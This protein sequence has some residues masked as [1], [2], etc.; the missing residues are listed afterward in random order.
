[1]QA[2]EGQAGEENSLQVVLELYEATHR[3]RIFSPQLTKPWRVVLGPGIPKLSIKLYKGKILG[4][5]GP[6]GAGKTTL[7]R[8]M[9]GIYPIK[10]GEARVCTTNDGITI[11]E[12]GI[13]LRQVVG[14]MPEQVRW[15][16][17]KT[18]RMALLEIAG[19][20]GA[21]E[22]RVDGLLKLVGLRGRA[23]TNLNSLSQGMRQR[24]TLA[25]ALLGSPDVL[26]LDEPFNGLDPVAATALADLLKRL[27]EK[28]VSI[29]I[30]SHRVE[31][32]TELVDRI[33]VLHRGQLLAE[34]EIPDIEREL[35]LDY[36]HN[37]ITKSPV[38][39]EFFEDLGIEVLQ[40]KKSINYEY[41]LKNCPQNTLESLIKF[42]AEVIT[43]Q[44]HEV[45]LVEIIC[46][47][48]GQSIEEVGLEVSSSAILPMR[49]LEV[50]EE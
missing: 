30:S 45:D 5:I 3:H 42:G 22:K 17:K 50:E 27:C 37:L 20:R 8:M 25:C 9:A 7:L 14:H 35:G 41:T 10:G 12:S 11:C 15:Q 16:G 40:E 21:S 13:D 2:S 49:Q 24:L 23:N 1:M 38:L 31:G 43:W 18:V 36:R 6:N 29:V 28:G 39:E 19:M 47:A 33:A 4:L 48:T 26:L 32:M 46:S 34:G 44:P